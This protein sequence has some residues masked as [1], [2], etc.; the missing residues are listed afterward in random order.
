MR[1]SDSASF[2]SQILRGLSCVQ[3]RRIKDP[4]ELAEA[5]MTTRT[6][7][8]CFQVKRKTEQGQRSWGN[9]VMYLCPA[10]CLANL[11]L[12]F[13]KD[14]SGDGLFDILRDG[15]GSAISCRPCRLYFAASA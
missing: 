15:A 3:V 2:G 11:I 4:D 6:G 1:N 10:V 7:K 8:T 9:L 5:V 12:V 13:L 14:L